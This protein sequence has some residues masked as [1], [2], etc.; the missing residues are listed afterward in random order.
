M[1]RFKSGMPLM[2]RLDPRKRW[3]LQ[4]R[5]NEEGSEGL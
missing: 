1:L 4:L 2:N 3:D 5:D